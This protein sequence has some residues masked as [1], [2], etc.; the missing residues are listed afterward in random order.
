MRQRDVKQ[1]RAKTDSRHGRPAR[2]G[3]VALAALG[4]AWQAPAVTSPIPAS[5][6]TPSASATN[7]TPPNLTLLFSRAQ[8]VSAERCTALPGA[9]DLGAVAAYLAGKAITPSATVVIDRM[10]DTTRRCEH[11]TL[12]ASWADLADLRDT[13]GWTFVSHGFGHTQLQNLSPE[14]A[15][16]ETCD[17]LAE[18]YAHGHPR[19]WGTFANGG[20]SVKQPSQTTYV[21]PCYA[22]GRVYDSAVNNQTSTNRAP[23]F[24]KTR[25]VTGGACNDVVLPCYSRVT[26]SSSRYTPPGAV[27]ANLPIGN[28]DWSQIQFYRFHIGFRLS[29]QFRWDCR[30]ADWRAHWTSNG[31]MYCWNDFQT[32][33]DAIPAGVTFRDAA[34]MA[35]S[36]GRGQASAVVPTDH[37]SDFGTAGVGSVATNRPFTFRNISSAPITIGSIALGGTDPGQFRIA[38]GT[39]I[40]TIAVGGSCTGTFTYAPLA[41]GSHIAYLRIAASAATGPAD[42]SIRLTGTAT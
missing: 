28:G 33:V 26:N 16:H 22:F 11:L 21:L 32:I 10:E 19:A 3:L 9:V 1:P 34:S 15:R 6:A 39:C 31:E 20:G 17:S 41:A 42:H 38:P 29:G 8:W 35:G 13:K 36:W 25:S 2:L 24:L 7:L 14:A 18:L 5:A 30:S 4:V 23:Y 12:T 40:G 27:I 37:A